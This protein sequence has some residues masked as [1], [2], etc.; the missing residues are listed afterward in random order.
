V[1]QKNIKLKFRIF[2]TLI[3]IAPVKP[4]YSCEICDEISSG[5]FYNRKRLE[6]KQFSMIK[7]KIYYVQYSIVYVY[8]IE[9]L[10]CLITMLEGTYSRFY[11][12]HNSF[13]FITFGFSLLN[14][15][16]YCAQY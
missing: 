5:V 2:Y 14:I 8:S 12:A 10:F 3:I 7:S 15:K 9:A 11:F 1:L 6:T 13:G 4:L 16:M